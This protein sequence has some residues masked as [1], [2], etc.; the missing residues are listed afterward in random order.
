MDF[1][2]RAVWK[3][4]PCRASLEQGDQFPGV[5]VREDGGV[6]LG[7]YIGWRREV[8]DDTR[9]FLAATPGCLGVQRA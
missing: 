9:L 5:Q 8:R 6:N 7:W 3:L 1:G 2:L 4:G